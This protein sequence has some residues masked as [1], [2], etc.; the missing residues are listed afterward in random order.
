[1][2]VSKAYKHQ[3][4]ADN[5]M[6]S[7]QKHS[8]ATAR[9]NGR[10]GLRRRRGSRPRDER[11]ARE[12]RRQDPAARTP[13]LRARQA[14]A[15]TSRFPRRFSSCRWMVVPGCSRDSSSSSD[16]SAGLPLIAITRSPASNA[17]RV[18]RRCWDQPATTSGW[19]PRLAVVVN[20]AVA[21]CVGI[22]Q[23]TCNPANW[24]K[25]VV[26]NLFHA[27]NVVA[28]KLGEALAGDGFRRLLDAGGV[29]KE[30]MLL[31]VMLVHPLEQ[32]AQRLAAVGQ[33]GGC[34]GP[35]GCRGSRPCCSS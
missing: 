3:R 6:E 11:A 21:T 31:G 16:A 24:K 5:R 19:P 2:P 28:K 25:F 29:G 20:P 30:A 27:G 15:S 1:M 32:I 4:R 7:P 14:A 9:I 33:S 23:P 34:A 26:G 8:I 17:Q 10:L 12:S 13:A 35:A 22:Q 18:A